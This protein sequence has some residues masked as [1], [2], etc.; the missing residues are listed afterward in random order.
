MPLA[1]VAQVFYYFS[2][3]ALDLDLYAIEKSAWPALLVEI[4][5]SHEAFSVQHVPCAAA[6]SA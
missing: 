5:S 1:R 6:L 3:P 4:E 2:I